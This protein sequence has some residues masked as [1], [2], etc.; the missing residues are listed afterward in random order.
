[1][2]CIP[3]E[4]FALPALPKEIY[5][6]DPKSMLAL[7]HTPQPHVCITS[8][9]S[10]IPCTVPLAVLLEDVKSGT[11]AMV[12]ELAASQYILPCSKISCSCSD[13]TPLMRLH[14]CVS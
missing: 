6:V 3:N 5:E 12:S 1:M 2:S 4:L 14:Q 10:C 9:P 13:F 8:L 11:F 7:E